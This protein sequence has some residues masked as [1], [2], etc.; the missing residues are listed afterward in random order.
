MT[1]RQQELDALLTIISQEKVSFDGISRQFQSTFGARHLR[2]RAC[3]HLILALEDE[4]SFMLNASDRAAAI[5]AIFDSVQGEVDVHPFLEALVEMAERSKLLRGSSDPSEKPTSQEQKQGVEE[6]DQLDSSDH[7][8][9]ISLLSSGKAMS[10]KLRDVVPS[11]LKNQNDS[12][13][14]RNK[15]PLHEI[16]PRITELRQK[17]RAV[18]DMIPQSLT[19]LRGLRTRASILDI[20]RRKFKQKVKESA[21]KR[22]LSKFLE[23]AEFQPEF[24]RP[25][26]EMSGESQQ[27]LW[28]ET[29]IEAEPFLWD[30]T[31]IKHSLPNDVMV[32]LK[33]GL[34]TAPSNHSTHSASSNHPNLSP[35]SKSAKGSA[36][37]GGGGE[38][39]KLN[40]KAPA[41]KSSKSEF[42]KANSDIQGV[43]DKESKSRAKAES[44][45]VE[46]T[47]RETDIRV[48]KMREV[49]NR[50]SRVALSHSD[51]VNFVNLM[52]D[53]PK[54]VTR[55]GMTPKKLPPIIEKNPDL[56]FEIIL[57][58]MGTKKIPEYF[59]MI[60][61][62]ELSLHSMDVVNRLTTAV[63]LPV[64][65]IHLYI[66]NCI[67]SCENIKDRYLQTR[68]VRL[69]CV[70]LQSLIRNKIINVKVFS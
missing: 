61:K 27:P 29:S 47:Y 53:N 15:Q 31:E 16:H 55:L 62:M 28:V 63:K 46:D 30:T 42:K 17:N 26:P 12:E 4:V 48:L 32:S 24:V 60:V 36:L 8:F 67:A 56:A 13:H 18:M 49:L 69:V 40:K 59:Q 22:S 33:S 52:R 54:I 35:S 39:I 50:S 70:F 1:L 66:V 34:D 2:F 51:S 21:F 23:V 45:L 5:F 57:K 20:S 37:R 7:D 11:D 6:I 14:R 10:N 43:V 9:L 3:C 64:E 25:M 19:G 41:M 38:S 44:E 58:L 68:L 65:F